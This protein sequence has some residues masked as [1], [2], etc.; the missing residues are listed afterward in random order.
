MKK[1]FLGLLIMVFCW[2]GIAVGEQV[3]T[4]SHQAIYVS[5]APITLNNNYVESAAFSAAEMDGY[6]SVYYK[7][8]TVSTHAD[9]RISIDVWSSPTG[10]AGSWC[11]SN[12]G[13]AVVSEIQE[14]SGTETTWIERVRMRVPL[15]GY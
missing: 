3:T 14:G 2:T 6:F 13:Y 10:A 11:R 1:L 5:N 8:N 7:F 4:G 15:D 12:D 9:A